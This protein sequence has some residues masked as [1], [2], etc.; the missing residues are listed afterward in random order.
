MKEK[1]LHIKNQTLDY[2]SNRTNVQKGLIIG[3]FI[4]FFLIISLV[5]FFGTRTNYAPLYSDLTAEESGQIKET[6]DARGIPSE[7]TDNGSTIRVPETQVDSLKVDLAA[8]GIPESGSIDYTFIEDQMGF[9]MTDNEFNVMERAA[10]QTELEGLIQNIEGVNAANVMITLPEESTWVAETNEQASASVV[11]GTSTNVMDQQ[12]VQALYHLVSKSVPNLSVDNIVIMNDRFEHLDYENQDAAQ[13]TLNAY[14]EQRSIQEDIEKDL[15][16]QIQQMLGTIMGRDKVIVSVTTDIDFTQENREEALIEPVDEE[17]MEG[18]EV[19]A[20]R[21]TETY[22][23]EMAE[24]GVPGAGE[25]DVVNYPAGAGFGDGDYERTEER[26]NNE[27]NRIHREI[28][29]SPYKIRDVGIQVMVEPPDPEDPA[30]LDP[31]IMNDVEQ[32]LSTVVTTS[33]D[34]TYLEDVTQEDIINENI[35]VSSHSFDGKMDIDPTEQDTIPLWMYIIAGVLAA[36]VIILLMM[37]VRRRREEESSEDINMDEIVAE[38]EIP[39][40]QGDEDS[41][42]ATRRKQLEKLAQENPEEF[43]KLLRTWLS[44]D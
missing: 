9:G 25:E 31:Q 40:L 15:Q 28:V 33:I 41:E 13:S 38:E 12:E 3:C 44:D 19:S 26:I 17:N 37:L 7:L 21:I 24:D 5:I 2:W 29:E 30:S 10:M 1:V 27:V 20:E 18:I 39:E 8:E 35:V 22:E 32:I 4:L 14:E 34:E 6:L 36:A 23:G 43:S 16:S 11:I 42:Q